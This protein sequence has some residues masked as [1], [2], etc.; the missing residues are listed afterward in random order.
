M[1]ET[2]LERENQEGAELTKKKLSSSYEY[3]FEMFLNT[4][5][6]MV[7]RPTEEPAAQELG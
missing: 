2:T 3:Q 1:G 7:S 6:C 4:Q 5:A